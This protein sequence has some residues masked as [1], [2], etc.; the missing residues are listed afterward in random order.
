MATFTGCSFFEIKFDWFILHSKCGYEAHWAEDGYKMKNDYSTLHFNLD[1][2]WHWLGCVHLTPAPYY[3]HRRT[4]VF[5]HS[6]EFVTEIKFYTIFDR[7]NKYCP[8]KKVFKKCYK[9]RDGY[10]FSKWIQPIW[11]SQHI[12]TSICTIKIEILFIREH[13]GKVTFL[14]DKVLRSKT[15]YQPN[16]WL[17]KKRTTHTHSFTAWLPFT[18]NSIYNIKRDILY[19]CNI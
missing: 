7:R 12:L 6:C 5:S 9:C 4:C 17:C 14:S 16:L 2:L 13:F 10:S 18:I 11:Y 8:F 1:R 3:E 19:K 15:A